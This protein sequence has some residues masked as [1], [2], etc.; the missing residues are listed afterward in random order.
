MVAWSS[1][2]D[3]ALSRRRSGF[4]SPCDRHFISKGGRHMFTNL[5]TTP[6]FELVNICSNGKDQALINSAALEL[7]YRIYV[8]NQKT[9]FEELVKN[10]GY[11]ELEQDKP[12]T[13]LK[14]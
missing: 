4:N 13:L 11:R 6:T 8:P 5:Q 12:K 14:S 9:T 1:G 7:A 3:D 2:Y 10:F